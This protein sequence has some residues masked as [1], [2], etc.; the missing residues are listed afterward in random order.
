MTNSLKPVFFHKVIRTTQYTAFILR[1]NEKQFAIYT[2]TNVG[3]LL[4][5]ITS[6]SPAKRPSSQDL[7]QSILQGFNITPLKVVINDLD[8]TIYKSRLFLEKTSEPKNEILEIDTR[9][10]DALMLAIQHKIPVF[11]TEEVLTFT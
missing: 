3:E 7:I 9:P 2:T 8:D 4:Q 5:T 6:K 11:I 10:S 1:S